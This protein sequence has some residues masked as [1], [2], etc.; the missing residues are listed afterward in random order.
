[1]KNPGLQQVVGGMSWINMER[2]EG[3]SLIGVAPVFEDEL[4]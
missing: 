2:F 3:T 4:G 1:M